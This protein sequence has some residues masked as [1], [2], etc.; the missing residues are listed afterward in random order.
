[1]YWLHL[2]LFQLLLCRFF[3]FYIKPKL[4]KIFN[5][6]MK[7]LLILYYCSFHS[8]TL[9]AKLMYDT[10]LLRFCLAL[11]RRITSFFVFDRHT[12]SITVLY[13]LSSL[14][15]FDNI[16]KSLLLVCL[17]ELVIDSHVY[18]RWVEL[19]PFCSCRGSLREPHLDGRPNQPL[20]SYWMSRLVHNDFCM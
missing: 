11:M 1:M 10:T 14:H 6:Y 4:V 12:C 9:T 20:P 19:E 17:S 8:W 13:S 3:W 15:W 2:G 7:L 5:G 16:T 18:L